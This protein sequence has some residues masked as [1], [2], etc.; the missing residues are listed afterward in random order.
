M[1]FLRIVKFFIFP[2]IV[3]ALHVLI[4]PLNFYV[5]HPW[6]DIPMH[7]LGGLSV[8]LSYLALLKEARKERHL[9]EMKK[10]FLFVF[11]ISMVALTAVLWE[12][13]EFSGDFIFKT[14]AQGGLADTM[15]DLFFGLIGGVI[16]LFS[17][18]GQQ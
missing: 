8:C 7:F 1:Y 2:I 9:G 12:F 14:Q 11:I 3:L 10:L 18:L 16:G 13:F 5:L 6:I 4:V 15:G 17:K